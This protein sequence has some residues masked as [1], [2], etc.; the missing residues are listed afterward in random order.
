VLLA[1]A[2]QA[3]ATWQLSVKLHAHALRARAKGQHHAPGQAVI[4]TTPGGHAYKGAGA[5]GQRRCQ[6][7]SLGAIAPVL[8]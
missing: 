2:A 6:P 5:R 3:A 7:G 4:G 8:R 1:G